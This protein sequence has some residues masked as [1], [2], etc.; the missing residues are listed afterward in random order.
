[1]SYQ[2]PIIS[3]ILPV[4]NGEKYISKS[5]E[6]ILNQTIKDFELIIINDGSTDNTDDII[7]SYDDSRII[8]LKND[9]NLKL[10]RTLN[11]GLENS[12]GKFISRIDADDIA[13][14]NLFEKQLQIFNKYY[15]VDF[16]NVR[17][18]LMSEDESRYYKSKTTISVNH[19]VH[20]HIIFFQNMISHPGLMI[21]SKIIKKFRYSNNPQIPVEDVHLWY[22]LLKHNYYC[23]TIDDYLLY[24][25]KAQFGLN[26]TQRRNRH[27]QRV[28]YCKK[29][30]LEEYSTIFDD[31]TIRIILGKYELVDINQLKILNDSLEKYIIY[32]KSFKEISEQGV[33]D[34]YYWKFH[35]LF[36]VSTQAF[37]QTRIF[38]KIIVLFY[39]LYKLPK[40]LTNKKWRK[41]LIN[42]INPYKYRIKG[43]ILNN[44]NI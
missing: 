41:N 21:K 1:M 34:L 35:L 8:Y 29:I 7:C 26:K 27:N 23:Y 40:W 17:T 4:Y 20:Q 12:K 32:I 9:T 18:Y 14:P 25:R 43:N 39:I 22:R 24:Y 28:A 10:I 36:I 13:F 5:I 3:V 16:I 19:D 6:S 11:I 33:Y 38:N 37:R 30:L 15:Y 42:V 31:K 2:N 44:F